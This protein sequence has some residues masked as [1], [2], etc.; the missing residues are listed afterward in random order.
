MERLQKRV[1]EY[2]PGCVIDVSAELR[3]ATDARRERRRSLALVAI[4]DMTLS[5]N[6]MT[7]SEVTR[8]SDA[9][10]E[11]RCRIAGSL[12]IEPFERSRWRLRRTRSKLWG[13][14]RL[15]DVRSTGLAQSP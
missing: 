7:L 10:C 3:L 4:N 11:R 6:D 14:N 1:T 8:R 9:R 13:L 12:S 2:K 5:E 15:R